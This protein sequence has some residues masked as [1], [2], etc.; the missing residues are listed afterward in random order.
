MAQSS[1]YGSNKW[2]CGGGTLSLYFRLPSLECKACVVSNCNMYISL[3]P[4]YPWVI[5]LGPTH[6]TEIKVGRSTINAIQKSY[7]IQKLR[8]E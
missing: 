2:C 5:G 3:G 7:I 4:T 8:I 6:S 1:E